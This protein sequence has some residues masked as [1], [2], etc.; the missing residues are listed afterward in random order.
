MSNPVKAHTAVNNWLKIAD[1]S[2]PLVG[3]DMKPLVSIYSEEY[4][5]T[6]PQPTLLLDLKPIMYEPD[7]SSPSSLKVDWNVGILDGTIDSIQ[8]AMLGY[9][10]TASGTTTVY[11]PLDP[12]DITSQ[13]PT[14][15]AS[16]HCGEIGVY[17]ALDTEGENTGSF[18][19]LGLKIVYHDPR[20]NYY[21]QY[22]TPTTQPCI[23]YGKNTTKYYIYCKGNSGQFPTEADSNVVCVTFLPHGDGGDYRGK[24][25]TNVVW[26]KN[27]TPTATTPSLGAGYYSLLKSTIYNIIPM[28]ATAQGVW[29]LNRLLIYPWMNDPLIPDTPTTSNCPNARLVRGASTSEDIYSR[30][31]AD[32]PLYAFSP[33]MATAATTITVPCLTDSSK[34]VEIDFIADAMNC[35]AFSW[36]IGR[37]TPT[38]IISPNK[39]YFTT[40]N[41]W[42]VGVKFYVAGEDTPRTLSLDFVVGADDTGMSVTYDGVV[43]SCANR[44]GWYSLDYTQVA[45]IA[46]AIGLD[47]TR[48]FWIDNTL[49]SMTSGGT[50]TTVA[51]NFVYSDAFPCV[52]LYNDPTATYTDLDNYTCPVTVSMYQPTEKK[53]RK[54]VNN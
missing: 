16:G 46:T 53:T 41:Y 23:Y 45:Q 11:E 27:F 6:T 43:Y 19:F 38:L 54:R 7:A 4:A 30:Y 9:K 13:I 2:A 36:Q 37:T 40:G 33:N 5:T 49:F 10:A 20:M 31:S 15:D 14:F 22:V 1:G 3:A 17:T 8:Y 18:R 25:V 12:V 39:N 24:A 35:A 51:N 48:P 50:T 42:T 29:G 52:G 28:A 47:T 21:T 34:N 44:G 32:I 26:D